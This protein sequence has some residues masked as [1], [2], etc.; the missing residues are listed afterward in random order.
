MNKKHWNTITLD[1]SIPDDE[2]MSLIDD[3]YNLVVKGLKKA[4]K[5]KLK[6]H[7]KAR[8]HLE[9]RIHNVPGKYRRD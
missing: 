8:R 6:K 3:S 9:R 7:N 5:E 2:I 4:D 1:G